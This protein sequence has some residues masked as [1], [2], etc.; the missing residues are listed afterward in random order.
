MEEGV[1]PALL[2]YCKYMLNDPTNITSDLVPETKHQQGSGIGEDIYV[3]HVQARG[4]INLLETSNP[5]K[6]HSEIMNMWHE[7]HVAY[8]LEH[9]FSAKPALPQASKSQV[10]GKPT[11]SKL[12][13]TS[14]GD[15]FSSRLSTA[16][17]AVEMMLACGQAGEVF[18]ELLTP[19]HV[20]TCISDKGGLLLASIWLDFLTLIKVR[21]LENPSQYLL[22]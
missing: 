10:S 19:S 12:S 11:A 20:T 16:P 17:L 18:S 14:L 1:Q 2:D 4:I 5:G 22:I 3:F 9:K 7:Q 13:G 15:S 6:P 8:C 21:L